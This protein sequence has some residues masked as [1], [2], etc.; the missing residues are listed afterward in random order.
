[1]FKLQWM[2]QDK[3][4]FIYGIRPV[5]EAIESGRSV[6]KVLIR[7][8][9]KNEFFREFFSAIR[10]HDIPYQFVPQAKLNKITMKNHQGVIAFLA[11]VEFQDITEI[12]PG[13]FERGANP[14][15]LLLDSLTD[16][17]NFGAIVRTAEGAGVD[18]IVISQKHFARI[19]EDAVKTSAGALYK[20]PVCRSPDMLST[21]DYLHKSGIQVVA[22]TEKSERS[23]YDV[24][25]TIP[26]A[27]VVGS[28]DKGIS[29]KLLEKL[30]ISVSIPL[31]GD[32]ESLNVSVATGVLLYEVVRQRNLSSAG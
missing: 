4:S 6:D 13:I 25:F 17:R 24:D 2:A 11:P 5:K 32:I 9:L 20:V 21:V 8:G 29:G 16:V 28:E 14:F 30:D 7:D 27:L 10:E 26:T 19:S 18:A 12:L 23:Y 15:I 22:V 31:A 3:K 1:M